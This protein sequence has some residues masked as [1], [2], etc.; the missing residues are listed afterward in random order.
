VRGGPIKESKGY[1]NIVLTIMVTVFHGINYKMN[2][3]SGVFHSQFQPSAATAI[4]ND[5][6][7]GRQ[8]DWS[9]NVEVTVETK[10]LIHVE[11]VQP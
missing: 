2:Y 11:A 1:L 7:C 10:S 4:G 8:P 9:T 6:E 5:V 3:G